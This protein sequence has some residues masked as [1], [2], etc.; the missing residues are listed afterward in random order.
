MKRPTLL[1]LFLVVLLGDILL[2]ALAIGI[3]YL[4]QFLN[5]L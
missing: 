5:W 2:F 4:D 3:A 1:R